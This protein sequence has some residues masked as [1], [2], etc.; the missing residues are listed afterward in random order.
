MAT[1]LDYS[2][3]RPS[4]AAVRAAGHAGVV[5]YAGTAGRTKN[6]TK[7]EYQDMDRNGVGV[8][9]VYENKAGDALLGR[10]AGSASASA[11]AM[12]AR[13]IGFPATRP[14]YLAVD[15]DITTQ[16]PTVVEY[17]RGANNV[18][19]VAR[20]GAYGEADVLD[21]LFAAGVITYGWQTAAWSKGR[22]AKKAHLFQRIGTAIVGGIGC[23]VN[24]IL[25]TDWGQHNAQ[26][27][28]MQ[29][30]DIVQAPDGTKLPYSQMLA[31]D[32]ANLWTLR[33][34]MDAQNA[35][36]AGL[37]AAVG[38]LSTDPGI[39][40]DSITQIVRDAVRDNIQITGTVQI[41]AA[42]TG[43]TKP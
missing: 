4:G 27:D 16:M 41:G 6:I 30:T 10:A 22:K 42:T 38:A 12:D 3:G 34:N 9:L 5:R 8:A 19:G 25:A 35:Q 33:R 39:T 11:I 36:L 40:K 21:A 18:L 43:G 20:T 13:N 7:A 17:F 31:E 26:E 1:A 29:L 32:Y 23:D 2:A 37:A 14:F 15:Q 28:D 24:D